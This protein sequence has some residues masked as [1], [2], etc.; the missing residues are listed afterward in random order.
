MHEVIYGFQQKIPKRYSKALATIVRKLLQKEPEKRPDIEKLM[1]YR[2]T[3]QTVKSFVSE[4]KGIS[5]EIYWRVR[6]P[7]IKKFSADYSIFVA[8]PEGS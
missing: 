1:K 5:N 7:L 8:A 6:R 3:V 4:F 2:L